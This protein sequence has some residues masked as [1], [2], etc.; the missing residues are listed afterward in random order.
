MQL[1]DIKPAISA[2]THVK[3]RGITYHVTGI[4]MRLSGAE[5]QYSLE[6][7]SLTAN[8]VTIAKIN[9]VEIKSEGK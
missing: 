5:W 1:A 4:I 7:H 8:S 3:Y 9:E 2:K 6:L